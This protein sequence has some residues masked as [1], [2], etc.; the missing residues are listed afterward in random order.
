[1]LNEGIAIVIAAILSPALTLFVSELFRYRHAK[2]EEKE[3]FFYEVYPKR[4]ELYEEIARSLAF[5]DDI[6]Q[7]SAAGSASEIIGIYNQGMKQL[8][9]LNFRCRLF[10]SRRVTAALNALAG[11]KYVHGKFTL[12]HQELF[13]S[14]VVAYEA[15]NTF[16]E[17]MSARK[18]AI[19][20]LIQLEAG[21]DLVDKKIFDVVPG[22]DKHKNKIGKRERG[23]IQD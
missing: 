18:G 15:I 8:L 1:M 11:T 5:V 13:D 16:T 21:T 3:R 20:E 10:G 17:T 23:K 19:V 22:L 7:V 4:M 9:L 6:E 2:R 12:D 14:E